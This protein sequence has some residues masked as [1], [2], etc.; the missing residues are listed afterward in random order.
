MLET[1]LT[2]PYFQPQIDSGEDIYRSGMNIYYNVEQRFFREELVTE[3]NNTFPDDWSDIVKMDELCDEKM[4]KFR[5]DA[6]LCTEKHGKRLL[7]VQKRLNIRGYHISQVQGILP[8]VV[9]YKVLESFPFKELFNDIIHRIRSAGLIEKWSKENELKLEEKIFEKNKMNIEKED[10]SDDGGLMF[11]VYGWI[12]S[13]ILFI[14]EIILK[15]FQGII[16]SGAVGSYLLRF[17]D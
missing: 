8:K 16:C 4:E 13:A 6:F 10:H 2:R 11:I 9:V 17:L 12:A 1:H 3:L 7:R 5:R 14:C 15:K